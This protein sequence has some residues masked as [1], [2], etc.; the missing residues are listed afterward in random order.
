VLLATFNRKVVGMFTLRK[1]VSELQGKYARTEYAAECYGTPEQRIVLDAAV[2]IEDLL[3]V[4]V[5]AIAGL[6]ERALSPAEDPELGGEWREFEKFMYAIQNLHHRCGAVW[7]RGELEG[8][9]LNLKAFGGMA[10][11]L[12]ELLLSPK[13]RDSEALMREFHALYVRMV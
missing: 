3:T 12:A 11:V 13:C 1:L 6:C 4:H 2:A 8:V 9:I 7:G 10:G 5:P